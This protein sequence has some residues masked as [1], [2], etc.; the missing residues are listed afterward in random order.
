MT[1]VRGT[2]PQP[3]LVPQR[4]AWSFW[5]H[6][7]GSPHYLFKTL[8]LMDGKRMDTDEHRAVHH[9]IA[10]IQKSL[11]AVG[12]KHPI[13]GTIPVTGVFGPRTQWGVKWY[14][15]QKGLL[16]D[17]VFGPKTARGLF[18]PIA[19]YMNDPLG[20]GPKV[21]VSHILGMFEHESGF[22]PGAVSTWYK[23]ENGYDRGLAQIN[24]NAHSE[25]SDA[26][27]FDP[28]F[29]IVYAINRLHRARTT[30]FHQKGPELQDNCSI[31]QHNSPAQ[32][33][34]WY[35]DG[36]PPSEQIAKYVATIKVKG[37]ALI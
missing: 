34:A 21:P 7:T 37:A 12:Y 28:L 30:Q 9:A 6:T 5:G 32:A 29:A 36:T 26:Q 33:I 13:L 4:G 16:E 17:G 27:A 24:Q 3:G 11:N 8:A 2:P 22:D 15:K 18:I 25:I 1:V 31:A 35:R 23:P 19:K 10:G 20:S 14:Q